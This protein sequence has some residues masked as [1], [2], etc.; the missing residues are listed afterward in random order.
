METT[1]TFYTNKTYEQQKTNSFCFVDSFKLLSHKN[2][3]SSPNPA[4]IQIVLN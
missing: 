3:Y 2:H 1:D 4:S